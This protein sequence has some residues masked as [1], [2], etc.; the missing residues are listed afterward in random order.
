MSGFYKFKI[1]IEYGTTNVTLKFYGPNGEERTQQ[2]TFSMPYNFL[3]AGEMEYRV[4]GGSVLDGKHSTY[5]KAEVSVGLTRWLTVSGGWEYLSSIPTSPNIPFGKLSL[6][7]F[8]KL[9]ITGEYAQGVAVKSTLNYCLGNDIRFDINYARYNEGQKAVLNSYEQER[10]AAVSFPVRIVKTH[11]FT[12]ASIRQYINRSYT[13]Q[14]ANLMLMTNLQGVNVNVTTRCYWSGNL[15][16]NIYSNLRMGYNLKGY[17][18][19]G[20]V[21]YDYVDKNFISME[22]NVDK[23]ILKNGQLTVG[24]QR[25]FRYRYDAFNIGFSYTFPFMSSSVSSSVSNGQV[26]ASENFAGSFALG[27]G[28]GYVHADSYNAVGRSGIT[29]QPFVDANF[30]GVRDKGE[31][32]PGLVD[33]TCNAGKHILRKDSMVRIVGLEPFEDYDITLSDLG[34]DV[35]SWKLNKHTFKVCTD[36]N[37]F[38]KMNLAIHP[39]GEVSGMVVDEKKKGMDRMLVNIRNASK[40]LVAKVQTEVDGFFAYMGLSPGTYSAEVDSLQLTRLGMTS[41]DFDNAPP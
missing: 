40:K 21:D 5:G 17:N 16:P 38:K 27:S 15:N 1:P 32:S 33:V 8:A 11:I 31:P 20:G 12:S 4:S 2:K 34:F 6:Q 22:A 37:Q 25:G 41:P 14:D 35:V 7:P 19:R 39:M 28:N 3:S 24:Y 26:S 18:L 30:N 23:T 9:L 13:N 29:V 36:P 10:F